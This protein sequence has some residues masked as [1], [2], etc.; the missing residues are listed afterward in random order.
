[1]SAAMNPTQISQKGSLLQAPLHHITVRSDDAN[2]CFGRTTEPPD[3]DV[4]SVQGALVSPAQYEPEKPAPS[5]APGRRFYLLPERMRS[6]LPQ[7]LGEVRC[8]RA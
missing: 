8:Y 5:S 4:G 2:L 7:A 6:K 3:A 1:M